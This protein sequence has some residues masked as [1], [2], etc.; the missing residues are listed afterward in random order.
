MEDNNQQL[1]A[2]QDI[3]KMMKDSSK[4]LSLSGL[5]GVFAGIYAL[6]GAWLGQQLL[7]RYARGYAGNGFTHHEYFNL[8]AGIFIICA[9]V[10]VFSIV[11][12]LLLSARKAKKTNQ[13]L[14]DHT[15]RRLFWNMAVPLGAGGLFCIA[16]LF[17]GNAM[18]AFVSPVMLI[19]YG[20]ALFNCSKYTLHEIRHLGLLEISI[21]L[22]AAFMPGYGLLFW[23]IGFGLLHIIYGLIMWLKYDRSY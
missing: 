9:A 4:F 11:T 13:K 18:A 17:Q 14:F 8:L 10:L 1:E 2:L 16:L 12:A 15:S 5:S 6:T 3:R 23:A 7:S 21:G 20:L 19:F 22:I